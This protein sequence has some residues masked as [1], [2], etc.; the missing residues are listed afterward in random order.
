M[1]RRDNTRLW[2]E[3]APAGMSGKRILSNYSVICSLFT[4]GVKGGFLCEGRVC[5]C[6]K[7]GNTVYLKE[8][9][10]AVSREF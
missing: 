7:G 10:P 2:G 9:I 3:R 5:S 8:E 4:F 1:R 6:V